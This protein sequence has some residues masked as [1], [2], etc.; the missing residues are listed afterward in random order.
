[1]KNILEQKTLLVA[2]IKELIEQENLNIKNGSELNYE[3]HFTKYYQSVLT[4]N[5][6]AMKLMFHHKINNCSKLLSFA[7]LKFVRSLNDEELN[8]IAQNIE[9]VLQLIEKEN[10]CIKNNT[11][12]E[13][14][15][16]Y[17]YISNSFSSKNKEGMKLF[18]THELQNYQT[19]EECSS[20]RHAKSFYDSEMNDFIDNTLNLY[21]YVYDDVSHKCVLAGED[22]LEN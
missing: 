9:E 20:I 13:W 14:A 22:I 10:D 19:L 4:N 18:I 17:R 15:N 8:K 5:V 12:L 1:M 16:H 2:Q 11:G 6:E 21:H 3:N 7:D